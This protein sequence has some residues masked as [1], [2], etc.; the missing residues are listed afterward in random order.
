MAEQI[1]TG[2]VHHATLTVSDV[3]R[4]AEFYKTYLGF[5]MV[6]AFEGKIALS[7]GSLLLVVAPA[8]DPTQATPDDRFNENRIGLD[9]ISFSVAS[10]DEL[11][12][13]ARL[14]DDAGVERGEIKDLGPA[15]GIYVMALRDPD[16]IQLEL[17][18]PHSS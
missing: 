17:T 11:E 15:F 4:S 14:L 3:Q 16:N 1:R 2:G 10:R 13:A 5:Q 18:A 8:P 9:H 12:A 6:V 7:N